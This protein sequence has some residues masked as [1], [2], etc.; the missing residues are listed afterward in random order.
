MPSQAFVL[1]PEPSDREQI[2]ANLHAFVMKALPGKTL[3]VTVEEAK[4]RRSDD[5]NRYLWGVCYAALRDATGQE[6][7]DWHE[8]ML[9]EWSGWESY[10]L[11]GKARIRPIRR[12]SKLSTTEFAEYVAF[13][14]C[15]AAEHGV[16][17]PDPE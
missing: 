16:F 2:A 4:K 5:Q 6:S 1:P 13:I 12:S 15:R 7:E 9:G 11:F 14:Q 3:K 8:Y 10:K 17:I